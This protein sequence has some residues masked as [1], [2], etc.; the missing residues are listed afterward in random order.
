M[1]VIGVFQDDGGDRKKN[2]V[3]IPYTSLQKIKKNTD[4]IDEIILSYKPEIGY[5]GAVKFE[6]KLKRFLK[7]RKDISPKIEEEIYI[8]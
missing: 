3:Y 8:Q 7:A 4:K 1:E 5:A 6:Q 2:A